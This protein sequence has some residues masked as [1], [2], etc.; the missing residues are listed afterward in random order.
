M[1][2][3]SEVKD[4]MKLANRL[5][6]DT[7]KTASVETL[8]KPSVWTGFSPSRSNRRQYMEMSRKTHRRNPCENKGV[9]SKFGIQGHWRSKFERVLSNPTEKNN[10]K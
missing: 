2:R 5:M 7:P 1:S 6:D 10:R 8:Q 3:L 4:T 9:L